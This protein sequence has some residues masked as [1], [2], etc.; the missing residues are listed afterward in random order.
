MILACFSLIKS[1]LVFILTFRYNRKLRWDYTVS[2]VKKVFWICRN[3]IGKHGIKFSGFFF[4]GDIGSSCYIFTQDFIVWW[5]KIRLDWTAKELSKVRWKVCIS[6]W[7]HKNHSSWAL[8]WLASS[9]YAYWGWNYY[10]H[11]EIYL[12]V[13]LYQLK[14]FIL[15]GF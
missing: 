11:E 4:Y 3:A 9:F 14:I 13:S 1:I 15:E 8:T 6:E 12:L 7:L 5:S 10:I 2:N